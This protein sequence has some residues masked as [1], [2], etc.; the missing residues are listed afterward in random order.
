MDLRYGNILMPTARLKC[1]KSLTVD[2]SFLKLN[3]V[4]EK[5]KLRARIWLE[6]KFKR[7]KEIDNMKENNNLGFNF[8]VIDKLKDRV[9]TSIKS[10]DL[11]AKT[12]LN[13]KR[14]E[15]TIK[16]DINKLI[17]FKKGLTK[18]VKVYPKDYSYKCLEMYVP[19][20]TLN[21]SQ[22]K[23]INNAI[24]YANKNNILLKIIVGG[25]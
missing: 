23:G 9:I 3:T 17:K 1:I 20:V 11:S 7:G 19:N 21:E 2:N 12:Y 15:Y 4:V 16:S 24:E 22:I 18:H 14:L 8:P 25:N 10:R 5:V 6:D 13:G